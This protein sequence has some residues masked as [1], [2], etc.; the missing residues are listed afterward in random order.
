MA[1]FNSKKTSK[2]KVGFKNR[3]E[4]DS[5]TSNVE[6]H[7]KRKSSKSVNRDKSVNKSVNKSANKPNNGLNVDVYGKKRFNVNIKE[8]SALR[9]VEE[10]DEGV[11][12]NELEKLAEEIELPRYIIDVKSC[13]EKFFIHMINHSHK[14]DFDP[15]IL[16]EPNM[17]ISNMLEEYIEKSKEEFIPQDNIDLE[18]KS[19]SF[20]RKR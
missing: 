12:D 20:S 18:S 16:G 9:R 13:E 4:T 15:F 1:G 8:T 10:N 17:L 2:Q 11:S 6:P 5:N 7:G 19:N 3:K 14:K